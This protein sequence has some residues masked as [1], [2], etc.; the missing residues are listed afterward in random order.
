MP[1]ALH[2]MAIDGKARVLQRL[3]GNAHAVERHDR[4]FIAMNQQDR[5]PGFGI[6]GRFGIDQTAGK[7]DDTG[8]LEPA[9]ALELVLGNQTFWLAALKAFLETYNGAPAKNSKPSPKR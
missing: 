3:A 7:A 5:R 6:N 8:N 9:A 4:V 1:G 2:H